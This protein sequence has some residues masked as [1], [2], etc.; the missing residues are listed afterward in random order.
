VKADVATTFPDKMQQTDS[1]DLADAE[2][3]SATLVTAKRLLLIASAKG[4][5]GKTTMTIN[6]AVQAVHAGLRVA[7]VDM[8]RQGTLS[9]WVGRR[10]DAAPQVEHFIIPLS[11]TGDGLAEIEKA[12]DIDLTIIDTPP[13]VEDHPEAIR[14]LVRRADFVLVPTGQGTADI[15]S[16]VEWMKF[17][18]REGAKAAFLL[19]RT[20][21]SAKSLQRAKLR[22]VKEGMLCPIDIRDLEDIS[23]THDA[24]VGVIEI[25]GANGTEDLEGVWAFIRLALD[26]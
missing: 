23:S 12:N 16:V 9:K 8:D 13:G 1:A 26:V 19:N 14:L 7:T 21:R 11:Q 6:L 10:P 3:L 15:E 25:R 17:L 18:K 5:S 4:G 20:K 2:Q 22:L 24:G